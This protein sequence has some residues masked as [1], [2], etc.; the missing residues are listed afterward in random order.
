MKK[1]KTLILLVLFLLISTVIFAEAKTEVNKEQTSVILY[2]N[3]KEVTFP[4]AQPFIVRGDDRTLVPIRFVAEDLG[5]K[6]D[7]DE[8]NWFKGG[9]EDKKVTIANEGKTME[10]FI[11]QNYAYINGEKK[12]YDTKP[13]IDGSRTF[14]P[15][16]F[17]AE[18]FDCEVDYEH[19]VK[20]KIMKVYITTKD[21][22]KTPEEPSDSNIVAQGE[23]WD[24]RL[25]E[26]KGHDD[27][28]IEPEIGAGYPPRD[29]DLVSEHFIIGIDNYKDYKG[30]NYTFKTECISHP[31]LNRYIKYDPWD[32]EDFIVDN[33][34]MYTRCSE[35][36]IGFFGNVYSLDRFNRDI[37]NVRDIE[38]GERIHLKEGEKM[39]FKTTISNGKMTKV[40]ITNAEFRNK[41][42]R[43]N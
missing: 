13:L 17:I 41:E 24:I 34:E 1:R 6:V 27:N 5:Y 11:G 28:W 39:Q 38:T 25:V 7:W 37:S 36:L 22:A 3:N 16:R 20:Q 30:T 23:G 40:Y 43:Y 19:N 2:I 26:V 12:E 8:E 29:A 32:D 10:L 4:D 15:L 18:N 9:N 33:I 31:Q 42:F 35:S 21:G 14:V